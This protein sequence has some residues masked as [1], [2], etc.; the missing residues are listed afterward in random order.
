MTFY[1]CFIVFSGHG[2]SKQYLFL[3]FIFCIQQIFAYSL[4]FLLATLTVFIRDTRE[5]VGII[6][7]IWFWFTPIVYVRTILPEWVFNLM[8][9][10]PALYFVE[11]YQKIFVFKEQPDFSKLIIL[12]IIG[13]II[14]FIS[15]YLFKKLEKD[16]RDFI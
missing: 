11:A 14:M 8:E 12:T 2:I 16:V 9:Y 6:M 7:Q 1:L 3:P 15:Y 13:H 5:F 10:N 4:G